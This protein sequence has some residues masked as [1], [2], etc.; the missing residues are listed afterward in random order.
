M[1]YFLSYLAL[2]P[3]AILCYL[4][5]IHHVR[6]RKTLLILGGIPL[7]FFWAAIGGSLGTRF[8]VGFY[9]WLAPALPLFALAFYFSTDLSIWKSISIFLA[10][11]AVFSTIGNLSV[12][13]DALIAPDGSPSLL[14]IPG[15]LI[16]HVM[17]WGITLAVWY[18]ATHAA[19]WLL[20]D[21]E[22]PHTWY[23]FWV[24]PTAF[25]ITN[26]LIRP[27]YYSTLYTNRVMRF[28]PILNLLLLGILLCFYLMF[29]LMARG[30]T[31]NMRLMQE[32]EF[33]QLQSAQYRTLQRTIDETRMARHDLRHHFTVLSGYASNNDMEAI[34]E[35][36]SSWQT[37]L[38]PEAVC[39][40]CKNPAVNNVL[41]YFSRLAKDNG[42]SIDISAKLQE[43]LI[44]PEPEFC[45]LLSNLLE[46]AVEACQKQAGSSQIHVRLLQTCPSLLSLTVDNT[47]PEPPKWQNN[48]LHSSKHNGTGIG[49]RSVK[50]IAARY[51]GDARFE[52]KNGMFY[53]S[54]LLN[55]QGE[56][57]FEA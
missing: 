13:A 21:L 47:C 36:L 26:H 31:K 49:T 25:W 52:W 54:V 7:F 56:D 28:Y 29:Y 12:A 37:S 27:R 48:S 42:I 32:N 16:F 57:Q 2:L 23:V 14:T 18:P 53:V 55:P 4:P 9:Q 24:F 51:H 11:G 22:T 20:D 17:T 45:V 46:N 39:S 30:L 44:I 33:L 1:R 50:N 41:G 3:A 5:V 8:H 19:R 40:Y 34:R 38:L 35:Y 43:P 15:C 10:V 6:I